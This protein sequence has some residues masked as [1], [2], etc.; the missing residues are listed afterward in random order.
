LK[1]QKGRVYYSHLHGDGSANDLRTVWMDTQ[2]FR[3]HSLKDKVREVVNLML[4]K[5][6]V[7]IHI[8]GK[9]SS[10]K[11]T[12]ARDII[13]LVHTLAKEVTVN[14]SDDENIKNQK[15][16]MKRGF[17]YRK[18]G[19]ADI[20]NLDKVLEELPDSK[21]KL[22]LVDDASFY[23][24]SAADRHNL[25]VIRHFSNNDENLHLLIYVSH[26][27]KAL[28]KYIR[29]SDVTVFTSISHEEIKPLQQIFTIAPRKI[30]DFNKRHN[31]MLMKRETWFKI[32]GNSL[33]YVHSA[34]FR[35]GLW[36]NSISMRYVVFPSNQRLGVNDCGLCFDQ[37]KKTSYNHDKLI[38]FLRD[39]FSDAY[40]INS[41]NSIS[42]EYFQKSMHDRKNV[43]EC[44]AILK[45]LISKN[46]VDVN[47]LLKSYYKID[48]D[49][50]TVRKNRRKNIS[51]KYRESYAL[52]F[53]SDDLV[54][55]G[56]ERLDVKKLRDDLER[57]QNELK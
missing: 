19:A 39:R 13:H 52:E 7:S 38:G 30:H 53:N 37:S 46:I 35:L 23:K 25:S 6:L 21:N 26:Y 16:K 12:L 49:E 57:S 18:I 34:P 47:E 10:G 50:L 29:Q 17:C 32:H 8:E 40:L 51:R 1:Y 11:T 20:K 33:K 3:L 48:D 24:I 45:R 55:D 31:Q 42:L 5:D 9:E 15:L 41:I 22:I 43:T 2:I 54:A 56:S 36:C 27:A 14:E 4:S 44:T 28:D